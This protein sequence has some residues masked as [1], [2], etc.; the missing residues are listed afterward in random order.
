M[1]F[2]LFGGHTCDAEGYTGFC[3]LESL[4]AGLGNPTSSNPGQG[5]AKLMPTMVFDQSVH[6]DIIIIYEN[7]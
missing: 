5:C 6:P 1:S 2:F 7:V 3:T 4:L